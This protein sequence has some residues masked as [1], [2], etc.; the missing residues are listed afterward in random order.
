MILLDAKREIN[1]LLILGDANHLLNFAGRHVAV[2]ANHD[3]GVGNLKFPLR[4]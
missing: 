3:R 2:G 1:Q 4:L